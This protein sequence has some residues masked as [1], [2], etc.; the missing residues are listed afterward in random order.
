MRTVRNKIAVVTGAASGIGRGIAQSFAEAGMKVVLSD[1]E[2]ERLAQ[3]TEELRARGADVHAVIA[4]VSKPDQVAALAQETLKRYG[5]V[6]VLC[7]NAGVGPALRPSWSAPLDDWNWVLGVNLMGVVHGIHTFI[8]IMTEQDEEAHIVNTASLAG[9]TYG[10]N[11][12]YAVSKYA[13]VGL[14]ESLQLELAR[15]GHKISVSVLCPSWVNTN[16]LDSDRNR[17]SDHA[18]RAPVSKHPL[19]QAVM[20]WVVDQVSNGLDPRAVGDQVLQA[21][22]N[23]SFYV[24]THPEWQPLIEHRMKTVLAGADPTAAPAPGSP[25]A[26]KLAELARLPPT[27]KN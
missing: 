19:H 25:L 10:S 23:K 4:D 9:L 12:V 15:D 3:T 5:A 1:V 21:I 18:P 17:P 22:L 13:V 24:L 27:A 14:S 8:P 26:A 20:D 11:T 16:I 6:H 2:H 7:N